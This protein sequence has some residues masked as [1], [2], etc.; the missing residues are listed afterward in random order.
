MKFKDILVTKGLDEATPV[1]KPE[2]GSG[3][4][5][6]IFPSKHNPDRVYKLGSEHAVDFWYDL[7]KSRPSIFPIVYKRGKTRMKLDRDRSVFQDNTFVKLKAGT[8]VPVDYVEMEK[9]NPQRAENEWKLL[10]RVIINITEDQW[11]FQDYVLHFALFEGAKMKPDYA[12]MIHVLDEM[13]NDY[14]DEYKMITRFLDLILE[15]KKL[16]KF[17]D[18]HIYNFGYDIKG[19]LKCLDI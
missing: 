4:D 15:I 9:L 8:I 18:L 17:P 10:N 2:L 7:F 5:H 19:N 1:E 11:D 14:P 6:H 12:L 16:N 3:A 13:K